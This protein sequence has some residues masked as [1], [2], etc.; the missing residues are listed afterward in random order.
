MSMTIL[1]PLDGS[2]LS[3]KALPFAEAIATAFAAKVVL[4]QAAP[5][6]GPHMW[7]TPATY[8]AERALSQIYLEDTLKRFFT[9]PAETEILVPEAEPAPAILHAI[10][11]RNADLV[12]MSTHGHGGLTRALMGSVAEAVL[13]ASPVPLLLVPQQVQRTWSEARP[14]PFVVP[15]DASTHGEHALV[16]AFRLARALHAHLVLVGAA[17]QHL[18]VHDM[19]EATLA[20]QRLATLAET[21]TAQGVLTT[22]RV[23]GE[24]PQTLISKVVEEQRAGL[25]VMATHGRTNLDRFLLG[26]VADEILR[27][28]NV[29]V[30]LVRPGMVGALCTGHEIVRTW[31]ERQIPA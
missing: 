15:L 31:L 13:R 28:V 3:E 20:H 23:E 19:D 5:F 24:S 6:P 27:S 2:E 30:L 29:P 22:I 4:I 10:E 18:I 26:S 8:R 1:V 17:D 21:L 7:I 25:V 11:S 9:P 16:P 12:V 14:L